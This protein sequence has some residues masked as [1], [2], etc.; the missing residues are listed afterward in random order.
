MKKIKKNESTWVTKFLVICLDLSKEVVGFRPSARWIC[1][2][3][4]VIIRNF[5]LYSFKIQIFTTWINYLTTV[6]W[7]QSK[8][9]MNRNEWHNFWWYIFIFRQKWLVLDRPLNIFAKTQLF[10]Y[11]SL[12]TLNENINWIKMTDIVAGYTWLKQ[13]KML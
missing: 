4:A 5:A 10:E 1:K 13:R 7:K 9:K 3:T 6:E 12:T 11:K 8:L 2:I